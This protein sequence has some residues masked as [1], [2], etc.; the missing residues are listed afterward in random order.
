MTEPAVAVIDVTKVFPVPF[1]RRSVAAVRDLNLE[2][3]S[4]QID[5]RI[6][7]RKND[8]FANVE[9]DKKSAL[10]RLSM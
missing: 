4:G 3:S 6:V 9:R 1:Q 10:M 8:L 2:A 7:S 5:W